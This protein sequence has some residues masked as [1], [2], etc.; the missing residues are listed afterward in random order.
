MTFYLTSRIGRFE[1]FPD[2]MTSEE[3]LAQA[4]AAAKEAAEMLTMRKPRTKVDFIVV[5]QCQMY[6]L[7]ISIDSLT[8]YSI[9]IHF[10]ATDS[11]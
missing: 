5:C 4:Q 9:D 3:I 8:L 6:K 10:D 11:F 7:L 1:A 2:K